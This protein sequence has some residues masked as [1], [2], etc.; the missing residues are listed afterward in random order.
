MT[1]LILKGS[2]GTP[3]QFLM[4]QSADH[5]AALTGASPTVKI[6][7]NGGTGASPTGTVSEVDSTNLPGLYQVAGNATDTNTAGPI[8][9]HAT[10]ASGD[11]VDLLVA[12]VVDPAVALVGVNAVNVGGTAQTGRD[13]GASVLLSPGTGTGQVNLSSGAVPVT[14]NIKKNAS[15]RL[16]F[17]MTDSTNHNPVIGKT[18]AGQVSIDG[19]GFVAL[20]NTPATEISNGDYT[21]ALAAADTNGNA[22]MFRFTAPG[23]DDLNIFALTQP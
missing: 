17:T 14:S 18:V 15:S 20:T 1:V 19:A 22:L 23:C 6:G 7:K 16:T 12:Q 3:L 4:V 13:I 8:W 21:I 10:A 11:P 2:T 9:L 5:I